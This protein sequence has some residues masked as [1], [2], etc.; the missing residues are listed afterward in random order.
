MF[1]YH[2]PQRLDRVLAPR[3]LIVGLGWLFTAEIIQEKTNVLLSLWSSKYLRKF[4][5]SV[6]E[7]SDTVGKTTAIF[8]QKFGRL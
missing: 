1:T 6:R 4:S 5:G 2:S 8:E 3:F 7:L